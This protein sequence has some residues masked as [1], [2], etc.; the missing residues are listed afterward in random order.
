MEPRQSDALRRI[1]EADASWSKDGH[2]PEQFHLHHTGGM[3]SHIEHPRWDSSWAIPS[4]HTIDDL[5]EMGYLRVEP[6]LDKRRSF[7]LTVEGREEAK[8]MMPGSRPD[9]GIRETGSYTD[10]ERRRYA[11]Q[12]DAEQELAITNFLG[13]RGNESFTPDEL[14]EAVPSPKFE[15]TAAVQWLRVA[16]SE[17]LVSPAAGRWRMTSNTGPTY[18]VRVLPSAAAERM[19]GPIYAFDLTEDRLLKDF[20][21]PYQA[22]AP[23]VYG[24]RTLLA[25]RRPT[26]GRLY[27]SGVEIVESIRSN[28]AVSAHVHAP[29]DAEELF[30]EKTVQD[31]TDHYIDPSEPTTVDATPPS[32][33]PAEPDDD[34]ADPRQIFVV[35]GHSR[36]ND[37]ARVIQEITG[38][39]PVLLSEQPGRGKTIIEKFEEHAGRAGFA[40]VLLTADDLGAAKGD[41]EDL[42]P[43]ARQNAILELGWFLGKIG[44]ENVAVLYDDGVELPSD[45]RGVEY[46]SFAEDWRWKLNRELKDAGF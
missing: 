33:R 19:S 26:V 34:E 24:D 42:H 32:S 45:Y 39:Q 16:H 21:G 43:R 7:N 37:V 44:R 31:V 5:E 35:H 41:A 40:V 27:A 38:R 25:Y 15:I 11:L 1:V 10:E 28:L 13:S 12:S 3:E 20:I 9:V 18:H 30:F 36:E 2:G 23:I 8:A 46:I 17:G 14:A 22:K 6:H 4:E 29:N